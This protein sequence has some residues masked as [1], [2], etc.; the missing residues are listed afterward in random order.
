MIYKDHLFSQ[1]H[2]LSVSGSDDKFDYYV[3]GRYYDNNGIFDSQTNPETYKILNSRMKMGYKIT[4]WLKISNNT[5]VSWTKYIMP[6]TYSEGTETS[7]E[8]S[9]TKVT[10]ARRSGTLT[11]P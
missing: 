6:Q 4:P 11:A 1:T 5:D 8:T 3:S 2:N 9:R 10:L 7:G